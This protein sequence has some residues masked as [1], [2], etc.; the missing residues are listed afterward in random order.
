[1]KS[2]ACTVEILPNNEA[3]VLFDEKQSA[4]TPGQVAVIYDGDLVAG[5]GIIRKTF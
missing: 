4:P 2:A 1:M 3:A 5:G